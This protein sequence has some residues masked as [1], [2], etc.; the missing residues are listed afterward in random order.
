MNTLS[1]LNHDKV[2]L[3]FTPFILTLKNTL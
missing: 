1:T 3:F 2:A